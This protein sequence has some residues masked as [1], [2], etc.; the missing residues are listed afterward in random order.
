MSLELTLFNICRS[1]H[2]VV[3]ALAA[4][5]AFPCAL[6][7]GKGSRFHR[8]A[9][10]AAVV[11]SVLVAI[12]G[13]CMLVNPLFDALW[14]KNERARGTDWVL[15]FDESLY[16]PHLFMWLNVLLLYFCFSGVRVWI[17]VASVRR[18]GPS[19]GTVD[20]V[21]CAILMV[22]SSLTLFGGCWNLWHRSFHPFA[23]VYVEVSLYAM[24][25]G[26][27]DI[28]SFFAP[29]RYLIDWG[30]ALHGYKFFCAWSGLMTAFMIRL[31]LS[32]GA[33]KTTDTLYGFFVHA[34]ILLMLWRYFVRTKA[35]HTRLDSSN[36]PT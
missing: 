10:Y 12:T 31:K 16:E 11:L 27:V 34:L 7:S 21:L 17:R 18:G 20:I 5:V 28:L 23:Y 32:Y 9:G 6:F 13:T 4:F 8:K 19:F 30:F 35:S 2:I 36:R 22:S 29:Q 24:L 3:G 26:A 1:L 15:F 33:L 14:L 25:F